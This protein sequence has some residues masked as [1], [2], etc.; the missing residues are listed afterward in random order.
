MNFLFDANIYKFRE[1]TIGL[2]ATIIFISYRGNMR[3]S[4]S[5]PFA[6]LFPPSENQFPPNEIQ[7]PIAEIQFP[8][9]ENQFPPTENQF[10]LTENKISYHI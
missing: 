2:L 7:F 6:G 4:A 5:I 3:W 10:P 9:T 8:L 1:L